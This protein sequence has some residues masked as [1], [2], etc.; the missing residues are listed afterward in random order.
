[1]RTRW[2]GAI[3]CVCSPLPLAG[4]THQQAAVRAAEFWLTLVIPAFTGPT[5]ILST[6]PCGKLVDLLHRLGFHRLPGQRRVAGLPAG[7]GCDGLL[8]RA[9]AGDWLRGGDPLG[10]RGLRREGRLVPLDDGPGKPVHLWNR[11]GRLPLLAVGNAK[12]DIELLHSAR[13]AVLERYDDPDWEYAYNDQGALTAARAGGT[14]VSMREDF[15][16]IFGL[17]PMA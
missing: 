13:H 8:D 9:G 15:V 5:R 12:G 16:H 17:R 4:S 2:T 1:M 3:P 11:A 14:V 7:D 10:A 6:S